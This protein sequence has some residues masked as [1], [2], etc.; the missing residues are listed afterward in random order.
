[1]N[2]KAVMI[3]RDYDGSFVFAYPIQQKKAPGPAWRFFLLDRIRL[4]CLS[5]V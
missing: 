3:K 5:E 2:T 1:M 4:S